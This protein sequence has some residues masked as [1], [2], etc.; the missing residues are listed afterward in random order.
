M[1][2]GRDTV[3]EDVALVVV[4]LQRHFA[5]GRRCDLVAPAP[6]QDRL[7]DSE[8]CTVEDTRHEAAS[9]YVFS[10]AA[11]AM[12]LRR[13]SEPLR[14]ISAWTFERNATASQIASPGCSFLK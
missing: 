2:P 12:P 11:R 1:G 5:L 7:V 4:G 13:L 3:V 10:T 8:M 6:R 9:I 14:E